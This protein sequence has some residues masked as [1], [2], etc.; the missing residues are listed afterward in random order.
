MEE[1]PLR[2]WIE[3]PSPADA[4]E[5]QEVCELANRM[6]DRLGEGADSDR[7]FWSGDDAKYCF[8]GWRG[9]VTLSDRGHW[10]DLRYVGRP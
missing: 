10:F 5:A 6:L 8:G 2:V 4:A 3:L 1:K 7:F 9:Y